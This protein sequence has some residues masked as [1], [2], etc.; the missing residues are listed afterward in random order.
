MADPATLS[1]PVAPAAPATADGS[2]LNDLKVVKMTLEEGKEKS[3]EALKK[4]NE[5]IKKAIEERIANFSK[6]E[7]LFL[8]D[9]GRKEGTQKEERLEVWRR[10]FFAPWDNNMRQAIEKD[11]DLLLSS[12]LSSLQHEKHEDNGQLEFLT[13]VFNNKS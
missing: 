8:N 10:F 9:A 4:V 3:S 11:N 2:L 12:L 7:S 1:S 5:L 6:F 13:A